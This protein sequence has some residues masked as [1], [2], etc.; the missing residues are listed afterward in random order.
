LDIRSS[1]ELNLNS[2]KDNLAK[3]LFILDK[4]LKPDLGES[5]LPY[6]DLKESLLLLIKSLNTL[7]KKK[8]HYKMVSIKETKLK[9]KI[10]GN[11]GK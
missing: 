9:K 10:G 1:E 8:P 7:V 4:T 11:I 5:S 2:F 6:I 3:G